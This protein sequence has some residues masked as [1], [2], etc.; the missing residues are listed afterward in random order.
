MM[1]DEGK[2]EGSAIVEEPGVYFQEPYLPT[3][4]VTLYTKLRKQHS[5]QAILMRPMPCALSSSP[6]PNRDTKPIYSEDSGTVFSF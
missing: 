4:I 1:S 3:S 5:V 6:F 2:E